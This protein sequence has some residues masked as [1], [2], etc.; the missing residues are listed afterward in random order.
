[1]G[2]CQYY[3]YTYNLGKN[4]D[5]WVYGKE[6][7]NIDGVYILDWYEVFFGPGGEG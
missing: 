3:Y 4:K 2:T 5:R 7:G 1:M 6:D